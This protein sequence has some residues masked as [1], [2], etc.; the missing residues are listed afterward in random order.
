MDQ[1]ERQ[2]RRTAATRGV[3]DAIKAAAGGRAERDEL[4]E[5]VGLPTSTEVRAAAL[6]LLGYK[7]NKPAPRPAPPP[8]AAPVTRGEA[9]AGGVGAVVGVGLAL[10]LVKALSGGR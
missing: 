7:K 1:A 6:G 9:G 10:L 8:R 4:R 5:E 2:E 3:V